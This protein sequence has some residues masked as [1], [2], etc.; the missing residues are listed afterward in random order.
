[1]LDAR[2]ALTVGESATPVKIEH[3]FALEACRKE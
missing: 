1:V 2:I 3:H